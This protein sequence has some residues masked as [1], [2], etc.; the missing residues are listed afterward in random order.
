MSDN[1]PREPKFRRRAEDRPDEVMDAALVLFS[2]Q[3]FASTTVDQ[4]A[5]RAGLSK[6]AV[7][8]Y[9]RSKEAILEGLVGRTI[10]PVVDDAFDRMSG[11]RGDPRP[12]LAEFL[13][14]IATMMTVR[15]VWAIPLIVLRESRLA[16]GITENFRRSVLDRALPAITALLRQGVEG[17][18]IRPVD[19]ELTA[20]TVIGPV[21]VHILL[22][23]VFDIR[24]GGGLQMQRLVD[25]HIQIL[26]AGLAPE[27]EPAA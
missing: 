4:I 7:Y 27:K 1:E 8:L 22:S 6:G 24:P 26:W 3:G 21:L 23:E 11:F 20:R 18:H 10:N 9:F 17:G 25:N 14:N 13:R 19:P 15:P 5:A 12:L 16:P 2:E